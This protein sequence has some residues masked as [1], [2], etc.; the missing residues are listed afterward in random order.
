MTTDAAKDAD[1]LCTAA[2]DIARHIAGLAEELSALRHMTG[3]EN[4][5]LV[6]RQLVKLRDQTTLLTAVVGDLEKTQH[7]APAPTV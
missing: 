2:R 5:K 6:D 7:L 3:G 1:G 4:A